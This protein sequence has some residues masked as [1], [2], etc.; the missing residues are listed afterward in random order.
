MHIDP[1]KQQQKN[2]VKLYLPP[3]SIS[4]NMC[5]GC[6]KE[7]SHMMWLRNSKNNFQLYTLIWKP[8]CIY[9]VWPGSSLL[10]PIDYG[11]CF[12]LR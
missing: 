2:S 4:L 10:T 12:K 6:S 9:G 1:V 7:S 5:F 3:L 8:G 11:S